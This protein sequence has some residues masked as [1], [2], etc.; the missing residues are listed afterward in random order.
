MRSLSQAQLRLD[1]AELERLME[2]EKQKIIDCQN[3]LERLRGAGN[4]V[5]SN[6]Q[7]M[8]EG[9]VKSSEPERPA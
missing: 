9:T 4:Y 7:N 5:F 1:L 8:G 2:E 6:L 3:N